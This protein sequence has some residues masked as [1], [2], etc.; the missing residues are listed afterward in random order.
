M[1]PLLPS[2]RNLPAFYIVVVSLL[3][4]VGLSL[5]AV[6]GRLRGRPAGFASVWVRFLALFPLW[7]LCL[8]W[9]VIAAGMGVFAGG[10]TGSWYFP[11]LGFGVVL[12]FAV[13]TWGGYFWVRARLPADVAAL[14]LVPAAFV[15]VY[16]LQRLWLCEPLAWSG[17]GR[18]QLCTARL[19]EQGAGGAIRSE[20]AARDWYRLAAE[21]GVPEAQYQVAEFTRD[22]AEQLAWYLRAA[23]QGHA[24]AA[25]RLYWLQHKSEPEPALQRLRFAADAGHAGAQY[26]LGLLY[27]HGHDSVARDLN[28][29]R[30]LWVAAAKGGYIS[31]MRALAV[32]YARDGV[33]FDHDAQR[34]RHW[35]QQARALAP[36][37]P[38]IPVIEQAL[39]WNWERV[40]EEV[41]A[42]RDRAE[43]G[44]A[45]AQ[46]ELA[47][48]ILAEA[49]ADPDLV[50]K[51]L[52]WME[53]AAESGSVEAQ[54]QLATLYL[55]Q[56]TTETQGR[57]W[58][59]RAA[60]GGH[61]TA[62]R[63]VISAFKDEQHGFPRDLERSKA[64]SERLFAVLEDRGTLK[65]DPDWMRA[66]W[67]YSDTLQQIKREANR[68][69]PEEE[70]T[71]QSDAGEPEAQY[72]RAKELMAT[73]FEEGIALMRA[74]AEAGFP[75]AQYEMAR[76]Y[77][78]RKRTLEEERQAVAWLS[79]AA[80]RDHR[81]AMVDLGVVYLQGIPRIDLKP[82]PYRARRLFQQALRDRQDTVYEHQTG[83]GRGWKY[84]VDSVNRWLARIPEPAKGLEGQGQEN[85]KRGQASGQR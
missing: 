33:L 25:Y 47:Q 7:V 55:D 72:H 81:G 78:T 6:Y 10:L 54:Y 62:L 40:L 83:G 29:T 34:S 44:D 32:A 59:L 50:A 48:E 68:Y 31:A 42:R 84:T 63:R 15:G 21:Q 46:R 20:G 16:E 35:A 3:V 22:R 49:A 28:R 12:A 39:A 73:R 9:T 56:D 76:R 67:Q 58:L 45:E 74:S 75:Q 69:L 5:F 41:R 65:N 27:R 24:G 11:L 30:A 57:R 4:M 17:L 14:L 8:I 71:R 1:E 66:S 37:K 80:A 43:A 2:L 26:R 82:D 52:E 77:R 85:T 53:R 51:A 60:D 38:D 64:Y 70:L 23:N 19:Y 36:S 61:E 13:L 79:A 18:A